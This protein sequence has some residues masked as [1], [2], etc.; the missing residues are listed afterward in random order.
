MT[1]YFFLHIPKTAGTSLHRVL[2]Q[3][4]GPYKHFRHPHEFS[5]PAAAMWR[6]FRGIGGHMNW[7][8]AGERGYLDEF[9]ITF[10]RDPVRRA[11]S[12]YSFSRDPIHGDRIESILARKYDILS[13]VRTSGDFGAYAN[14]QT[15][16]LSGLPFSGV[17]P[18]EHLE[19]ALLNLEKFSF[20]GI[21]E[22]FDDEVS[23]LSEMLGATTAAVTHENRTPSPLRASDLPPDTLAALEEANALDRILYNR[24]LELQAKRKPAR[25]DLDCPPP[26]GWP[27]PRTETGTRLVRITQVRLRPL[28][29]PPLRTGESAEL[30]IEY[31]S[32]GSLEGANF[33]VK[34]E[35]LAGHYIAGTNTLLLTGEQLC[36]RFGHNRVFFRFAISF[37]P[38]SYSLAV[39]LQRGFEELCRVDSAVSF[40]VDPALSP[41]REGMVDIDARFLSPRSSDFAPVSADR[42]KDI[43]MELLPITTKSFAGKQFSCPVR[44]CN[45]SNSVLPNKE[46]NPICVSYHWVAAAGDLRLHDGAR[47]WI[48]GDLWPH[49]AID[50]AVLVEAPPSPG[51]WLLQIRLVSE[52]LLWLEGP[53]FR[54]CTPPCIKVNLLNDGTWEL[55]QAP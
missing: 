54:R 46:P 19:S 50:S 29:Q 16:T 41:Y 25:L 42:L 15:A 37:G 17:S 22:Q 51:S 27:A 35:D 36:L 24:A 8:Q 28:P 26:I 23:R 40:D 34:I 44:I 38:G 12:Q 53:E 39:A 11:L 47:T 7:R 30:E 21:A 5:W 4:A 18:Q 32:Y 2:E 13:L 3:A 43:S 6:R 14:L 9:T 31:L 20:L 49:E 10:L 48:P 55:E 45:H 33:T 52:G 1:R